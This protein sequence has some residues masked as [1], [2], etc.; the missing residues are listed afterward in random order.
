M[1]PHWGGTSVSR[2]Q[3]SPR[4]LVKLLPPQLL[5]VV[6]PVP[7]PTSCTLQPSTERPVTFQPG[8]WDRGMELGCSRLGG[9]GGISLFCS[10]S[11][12]CFRNPS[13]PEAPDSG[14][15]APYSAA[16]LELQPGPGGSGYPAAAP[17]APFPSHFLQGGPFPLAYPGPGAY[18]DVGSKPMY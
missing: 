1:I 14:R 18:L 3:S 10:D 12:L 8:E 15:P 6:V 11:S 4:P 13:F 17:T 9:G 2:I 16:F 7:K 5:G